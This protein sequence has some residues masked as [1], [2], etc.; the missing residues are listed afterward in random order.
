MLSLN[1]FVCL[2]ILFYCSFDLGSVAD[3]G[4]NS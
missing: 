4:T 3:S 2:N 1:K